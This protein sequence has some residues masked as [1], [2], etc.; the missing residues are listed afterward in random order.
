[1]LFKNINLD[2]FIKKKI[3]LFLKINDEIIAKTF[4]ESFKLF[5]SEKNKYQLK[6]LGPQD[7]SSLYNDAL[8]IV[9]YGWKKEAVPIIVQ[10]KSIIE[11]F[12]NLF[13]N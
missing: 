4:L 8:K 6:F 5:F 13:F 10:K 3:P 2:F 11:R 9:H 12:F 1:M 7:Y